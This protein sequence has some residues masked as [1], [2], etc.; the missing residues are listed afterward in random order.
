MGRWMDGKMHGGEG[1][2]KEGNDFWKDVYILS[3]LFV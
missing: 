1:G 3:S 2:R